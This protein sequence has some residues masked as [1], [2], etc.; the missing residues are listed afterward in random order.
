MNR[1]YYLLVISLIISVFYWPVFAQMKVLIGTYDN[2]AVAIAYFNSSEWQSTLSE[3]RLNVKNAQSANN[4][5]LAQQLR[6]R[7]A[8]SQTLA[9]LCG[10]SNGSVADIL[11]K[12][13]TDVESLA[14]SAKV[15]AIVSQYEL[16][17]PLNIIETVDMTDAFVRLFKPNEKVLEWIKEALKQPPMPMIDVLSSSQGK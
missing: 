16:I 6:K 4:D 1:S 15:S 5:S 10:F 2:R 14:K 9:H 12:H 13:R 3:M 7:G 17:R 8:A 11:E